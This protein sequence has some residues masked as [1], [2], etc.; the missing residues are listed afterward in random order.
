MNKVETIGEFY[1]GKKWLPENLR[2]ELGHFNVF[3]LEPFVGGNAKPV[4]YRRRDYFKITLVIGNAKVHFADK[5]VEVQ[6]H[7][8]AFSNPQIPYSWEQK[9]RIQG[10]YFCI[11]TQ[12][13]FH[14]YGDLVQYK[15][16]QP[17]GTPVLELT[18]EQARKA[19]DV[20]ERMLE[21][22]NSNYVHKFDVLRT[23][24]FELVHLA[25]KMY[26]SANYEKQTVNASQRIASLFTELLERQFPID[27]T[28]HKV[29]LRSAADFAC[30]LNIHVNHLNRAVKEIT[31]KT[32]SQLI[33]ER[34]LQE[35]KVLLKHTL[36]NVSEIAYALGFTEVT[37][38]NNFFKKHMQLSPSKFRN[39]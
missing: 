17:G 1:K 8:L 30:Q 22:L 12:D 33:A 35:A 13:F 25:L 31:Q 10:G 23:L 27:D 21:E 38:F 28:Y 9:E 24:V 6:K 19:R 5:V 29:Q 11:F 32:T 34:I 3:R 2:N 26:P 37:H 39:A 20:Y 15:V 14:Q 16:F 4:P 36:W 18:D 7:A